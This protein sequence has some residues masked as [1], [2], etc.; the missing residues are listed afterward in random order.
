MTSI[1]APVDRQ[2][3]PA[4]DSQHHLDT[5]LVISWAVTDNKGLG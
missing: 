2:L 4:V 1:P 3:T 5:E